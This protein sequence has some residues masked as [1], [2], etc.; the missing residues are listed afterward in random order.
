MT[1]FGAVHFRRLAVMTNVHAVAST[2]EALP[3]P[4]A[5]KTLSFLLGMRDLERPKLR[6]GFL[7]Q[8]QGVSIAR[9]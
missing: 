7:D 9:R 2:G 4:P 5:S 6:A 3:S 8:L 1:S